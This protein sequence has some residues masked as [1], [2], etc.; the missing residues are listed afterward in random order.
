MVVGVVRGGGGVGAGA[1]GG[2]G[3]T[4][5]WFGV[6]CIVHILYKMLVGYTLQCVG[7]N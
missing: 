1:E 4:R 3:G 2:A 5:R 6:E 7:C